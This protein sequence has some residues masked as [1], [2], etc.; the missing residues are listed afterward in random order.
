MRSAGGVNRWVRSRC[1]LPTLRAAMRSGGAL[2]IV[3]IGTSLTRAAIFLAQVVPALQRAAPGLEIDLTVAGMS[4]LDTVAIALTMGDVVQR[5]ADLAI[6]ETGI[7]DHSPTT[8][9]YA[10]DAIYGIVAQLRAAAPACDIV[11]AFNG[12]LNVDRERER[13]ATAIHRAAAEVLGF[14][15]IDLF[16]YACDAIDRGAADA[17][18]DGD[19]AIT[20]DGTHHAAAAAQVLG[21]P[22]AQALIDIAA[23]SG[24]TVHV[25]APFADIAAAFRNVEDGRFADAAPVARFDGDALCRLTLERHFIQDARLGL[26]VVIPRGPA[27]PRDPADALFD[28]A[29]PIAPLDTI[30]SDGW[31]RGSLVTPASTMHY[32]EDILIAARAGAALRFTCGPFFGVMGFNGGGTSL[33]ITIDGVTTVTTPP[34]CVDDEQRPIPWLL[35]ASHG[36]SDAPHMVE[37]ACA[38]VP[39][40]LTDILTIAP[41]PS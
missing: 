26:D 23:S 20:T 11:F 34:A 19:R 1:G 30:V 27:Y 13:S 25:L 16:D 35:A 12:R 6:I 4:A 32:R 17:I 22:F 24:E 39:A 7:N 14:P 15:S 41:R 40:M 31:A 2:R 5:G 37:I 36:L 9:A 29:R 3:A 33:R 38:G 10:L 8:R 18:G 28:R 21:V